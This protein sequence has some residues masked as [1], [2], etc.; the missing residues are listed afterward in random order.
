M[1]KMFKPG[2][3]FVKACTF[4]TQLFI[5]IGLAFSI[6]GCSKKDNPSGS[7]STQNTST[8]DSTAITSATPVG[9]NGT[10]ADPSDLV[11]NSTFSS[12]V[13]INFGATVSITN[14]L[15]GSGVSIVQTGSDIVIT[16]TVSQVEYQLSGTTTNGSVK[17]YS[18]NKFELNLNNV[19]ITSS[20][21][22]AI[23]IQTSKTAYVVIADGTTNTLVDAVTYP[24]STEDQKGTLCSVGQI[25]FSGT[26][27]LTVTGNN[28]HAIV[29]DQYIRVR[30]G[31]I[32]VTGAVKDA[33]H[34]SDYFI[35]DGGTLNL[36]ASDD[37]IECD[38]GY[39]IINDGTF[40]I[41]SVSHGITASYDS[42]DKTIVP[43]FTING[44]TIKA[45]VSAGEGIQCK[46]VLTINNGNITTTSTD[47]GM[48]A[49]TAIYINNGSLY[50]TSSANDGMESNGIV[51]ITGGKTVA[52]GS[53]VAKNGVNC[54]NRAFKITGGLVL[55][56]GAETSE[57]TAN[58]ST[59]NSVIMGAG[60]ANQL[61]H[62]EAANGT[63][64]LT[65][66]SPGAFNTM[67]Y[68]CSK[69]KAGTTYNVYTGGSVS[70]K[71]TSFN[72]LYTSGTYTKGTKTGSFTTSSV[73]TQT[74]G[75]LNN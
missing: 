74:G 18:T 31:N 14:P 26:G 15:S 67:L 22:P 6:A 3:A 12:T 65:F 37:G 10:G 9:L 32:T 62:I 34:S 60:T 71:N 64:A 45:T 24:T 28:K 1:R 47:D 20:S 58:I 41:N 52:I 57:P 42:G 8:I 53:Q 39:I 72:G 50:L 43:Y 49:D 21:G 29:S 36:T 7:S 5:V 48:N 59:I 11:E 33:M 56:T 44:G 69:L 4:S 16:S 68:A 61:I 2:N 23:N 25:V 66:L 38:E 19:S 46:N 17:I 55:G 75:T 40:N 13:S 54:G 27:N 35:V 51:T 63:E 70:S 73:V 30:S